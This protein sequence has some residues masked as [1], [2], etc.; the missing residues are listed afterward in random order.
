MHVAGWIPLVGSD[1]PAG[2]CVQDS[3]Q[4]ELLA[5]ISR[6]IILSLKTLF[7]HSVEHSHRLLSF[8]Q[9]SRAAMRPSEMEASNRMPPEPD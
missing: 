8:I 7:S 6:G 1:V 4:R 2:R 3:L 9:Q 5:S